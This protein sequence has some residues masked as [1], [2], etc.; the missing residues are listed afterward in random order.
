MSPTACKRPDI[1]EMRKN[2][3]TTAKGGTRR[4][5]QEQVFFNLKEDTL[6]DF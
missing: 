4:T 2:R 1:S 6:V 5:E 3:R